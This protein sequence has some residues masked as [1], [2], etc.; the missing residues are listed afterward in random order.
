MGAY[1]LVD[2]AHSMG[3]LGERGRG[4]AEAAGVEADVDFIVGTFS[5]SLGSVG[6]FVVSNE[7]NFD[8]LRIVSRPYMFTASL[9]PAVVASTL[10][11]LKRLEEDSDLRRRL[12]AN[13]RHLFDGLRDLG[14]S[15]GPQAS[16]IA[17]VVMPD[18]ATAV[19]MWNALMANGVYLNL[20]VP[21]AT[22]ENR[23]LLRSS[24]SAA[25]TPEQIEQVLNVFA[26]LGQEFGLLPKPARQAS[27]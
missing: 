6:G 4:L 8:L 21:P 11:A 15:M 2:E 16:P 12:D 17:A 26:R 9:P 3:V 18:Q 5:K 23:S 20:A 1:L 19:G 10:T 27:A 25:H 14:F 22:P 7:A 13:A 24:V